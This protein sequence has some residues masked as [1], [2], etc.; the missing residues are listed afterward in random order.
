VFGNQSVGLVDEQHPAECLLA[1]LFHAS[2]GLGD[3]TDD[4]VLRGGLHDL[5][6]ANL[7]Q[8][9]QDFGDDALQRSSTLNRCPVKG[10]IACVR[11][12]STRPRPSPGRSMAMTIGP[13]RCT[14]RL[15]APSATCFPRCS[16]RRL[17][18][19]RHAAEHRMAGPLEDAAGIAG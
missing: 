12:I 10:S 17:N 9:E 13:A 2:G 15:S 18:A 19:T 3:V 14:P 1:D 4:E 8:P 7:A 6:A 11:A 5:G 16:P